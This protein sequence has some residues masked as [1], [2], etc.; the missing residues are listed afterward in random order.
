[1]HTMVSDV[2]VISMLRI[3]VNPL[4]LAPVDTWLRFKPCLR[5][6]QRTVKHMA[7]VGW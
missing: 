5:T 4:E 1:M 7:G 2:T 3:N 6:Y